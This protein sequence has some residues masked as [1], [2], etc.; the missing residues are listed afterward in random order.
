[1]E[2]FINNLQWVTFGHGWQRARLLDMNKAGLLRF[3]FNGEVVFVAYAAKSKPGLGARISAYRRGAGK[4]GIAG[5]LIVEHLDELVL[6][7]VE[8]DDDPL[9]IRELCKAII[10]RDKPAW[11]S[12]HGFG[13][14]I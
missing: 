10:A 1:M 3:W 4:F 12:D 11:N 6:E 13:G 2:K 7:V 8:L 9:F 14:R 5:P